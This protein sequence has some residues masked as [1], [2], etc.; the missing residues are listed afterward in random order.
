MTGTGETEVSVNPIR[1]GG[2]SKTLIIIIPSKVSYQRPTY[3]NDEFL[4]EV[5]QYTIKIKTLTYIISYFKT[6]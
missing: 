2:C 3:S 1:L 4:A 6:L 5:L